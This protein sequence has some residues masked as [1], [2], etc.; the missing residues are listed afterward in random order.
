[1]SIHEHKFTFK[2]LCWHSITKIL[3]NG[4]RAHFPFKNEDLHYRTMLIMFRLISRSRIVKGIANNSE[5]EPWGSEA[6]QIKCLTNVSLKEFLLLPGSVLWMW[7]MT[8]W[9]VRWRQLLQLKLHRGFYG[10]MTAHTTRS[11]RRI[12][13]FDSK[14]GGLEVII[15]MVWFNWCDLL[16]QSLWWTS[17]KSIAASLE[18]KRLG[19]FTRISSTV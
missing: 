14:V 7:H 4:P 3:R 15:F 10:A 9:N 6:Q 8:L 19:S 18:G 1:L 13:L 17:W 11:K 16:Y 5:R 2:H 12:V